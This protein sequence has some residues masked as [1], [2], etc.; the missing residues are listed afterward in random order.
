MTTHALSRG[1]NEALSDHYHSRCSG[2]NPKP[3]VLALEGAG[4]L[5][6]KQQQIAHPWRAIL[7]INSCINSSAVAVTIWL[8]RLLCLHFLMRTSLIFFLRSCLLNKS[9]LQC[10][11]GSKNCSPLIINAFKRRGMVINMKA[12]LKLRLQLLGVT[13][14]TK[15]T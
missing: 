7:C 11:I 8:W 5:E 13:Q 12:G 3:L 2:R 1:E 4:S 9:Q 6:Q 10:G 15:Y 14:V